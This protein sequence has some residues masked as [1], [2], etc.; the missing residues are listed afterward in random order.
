LWLA[1]IA[2]LCAIGPSVAADESELYR[3][4]V[5]VTGRG[6][7]ERVRGTGLAF[8]EVLVKVSGDPRLARDPRVAEVAKEADA[9]V[10]SY[11]YRD[12]MQGLALHD[13][14]GTRDRPHDLTIHFNPAKIDTSLTSLGSAPWREPRPRLAV[15]LAIQDQQTRYVLAQDG[16][17]G[18]SQR[19]ALAAVAAKR[20]LP[21]VLP[22][23]A[24][25]ETE[26]LTHD[27]L[28]AKAP[29]ALAPAAKM[30]GGDAAL[31]GTL[32]WTESALGWSASW[33]MA[34]Q[35]KDYRWG[36]S[37]VSFDDAFRN[38]IDGAL[39]ILSGHGAPD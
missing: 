6:E 33:R 2:L 34:R 13:E 25:I 3:T 1:L 31:S 19:Q 7:A 18:L 9:L 4:T 20:A 36:V 14:Q 24:L 12:R 32:V 8:E 27:A 21:M 39:E 22:K 11:D 30:A 29:P 5:F 26:R 23:E 37:G 17:R 10:A 28:A 15:F 16:A 35:G 38:A